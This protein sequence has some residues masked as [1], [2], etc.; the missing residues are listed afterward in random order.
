MPPPLARPSLPLPPGILLGEVSL[1][2]GADS[3]GGA[4][5]SPISSAIPPLSPPHEQQLDAITRSLARSQLGAHRRDDPSPPWGGTRALSFSDDAPPPQEAMDLSF[6][7]DDDVEVDVDAPASPASPASPGVATSPGAPGAPASPSAPSAPG[8]PA[9]WAALSFSFLGSGAKAIGAGLAFMSRGLIESLAPPAVGCTEL[10][11]TD[12][13]GDADADADADATPGA[14]AAESAL[15]PRR[16]TKALSLTSLPPLTS[17]M[18]TAA[19]P[20]ASPSRVA[21]EATRRQA[22][23]EPAYPAWYLALDSSEGESAAAVEELIEQLRKEAQLLKEQVEKA[24]RQGQAAAAAL[25]EADALRSSGVVEAMLEAQGRR[26]SSNKQPG[27]AEVLIALERGEA[28][29]AVQ[30][31]HGRSPGDSGAGLV[32]STGDGEEQLKDTSPPREVSMVERCEPHGE[33]RLPLG[34]ATARPPPLAPGA[35]PVSA[36]GGALRSGG[37]AVPLRAQREAEARAAASAKVADSAAAN[38]QARPCTRGRA[39]GGGGDGTR[40][41]R[42]GAAGVAPIGRG[43]L[44]AGQLPA[45]R[46]GA[47]RE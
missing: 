3:P 23:P 32:S 37:A 45:G 42:A 34:S 16:D 9:R 21:S 25:G 19:S 31:S 41:G 35:G 17:V 14:A 1:Q 27:V 10:A 40:V 24:A 47:A 15:P 13:D 46:A 12:T 44:P 36:L 2:E 4:A 11:G 28:L 20:P 7:D 26:P 30:T 29:P 33:R 22:Q 8:A 5:I 43:P 18:R 38:A 6:G 39:V